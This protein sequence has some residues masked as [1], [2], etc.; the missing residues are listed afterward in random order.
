MK[1]DEMERGS[2]SVRVQESPLRTRK[3][4]TRIGR[5][6]HHETAGCH[7]VIGRSA[8]NHQAA[9]NET[10]GKIEENAEG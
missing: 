4:S 10:A 6:F 3:G 7:V 8:G 9:Q 2:P 5:A 1:G